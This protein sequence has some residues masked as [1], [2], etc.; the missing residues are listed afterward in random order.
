MPNAHSDLVHKL[1]KALSLPGCRVWKN[2]TG[3]ARAMH[4]DTQIIS[5][6]LDGSADITGILKCK[7]GI[8]A[9]L[10]VECKTG[11]GRLQENQKN[12]RDMII[13][14]GGLHIEARDVET[15]VVTV[16]EFQENH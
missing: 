8:G 6:G 2:A 13:R 9:R 4:D 10:E 15:V 12:F 14:M 16:L 7:S 5:Y 1:L 3:K 11:T